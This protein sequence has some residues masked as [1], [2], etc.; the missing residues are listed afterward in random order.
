MFYLAE[1]SAGSNADSDPA[2]FAKNVSTKL[3]APASG[4]FFP[5]AQAWSQTSVN[6]QRGCPHHAGRRRSPPLLSAT[7]RTCAAPWSAKIFDGILSGSWHFLQKTA[8]LMTQSSPAKRSRYLTNIRKSSDFKAPTTGLRLLR[9]QQRRF[10]V[11]A[12]KSPNNDSSRRTLSFVWIYTD[13]LWFAGKKITY[14]I[15]SQCMNFYFKY[16]IVFWVKQAFNVARA[17]MH[18]WI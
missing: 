9:R 12:D 15:Y 14:A 11:S 8:Q 1:R 18:F 7:T 4:I 2:D 5:S 6:P 10:C 17:N 3:W 13:V 16:F